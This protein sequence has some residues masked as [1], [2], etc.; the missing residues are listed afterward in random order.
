LAGRLAEHLIDGRPCPT[1]GATDHPD[2]ATLTDDTPGDDELEAAEVDSIARS[3]ERQRLEVSVGEARGKLESLAVID[4]V[5]D[6]DA[7]LAEARCELEAIDVAVGDQAVHRA[8]VER[9][10]KLEATLAEDVDRRRSE[11]DGLAGALAERRSRWTADRNAFVEEHGA[12]DSTADRADRLGS[13]VAAIEELAGN[14]E[15]ITVAGAARDGHRTALSCSMVEFGVDDPAGLERWARTPDQIRATRRQLDDR[16]EHRRLVT[17]RINTYVAADGPELEPDVGPAVEAEQRAAASH[18]DL[19]GRAAAMAAR[20][21]SLDAAI[22]ELG[23]GSEAIAR[24]LVAK[25]EADTLAGL[26]AGLGSGPDA[27]RLSLKNWVLAYY[28]RQVLAHAN[29]RLHTMTNGRYALDLSGEH[30]D[31]RRPWG[32]DISVRDAETGQ[33][34]PATTLSGGETFM[35]ALSLALGLADVVSAGSNYSIGALFVDEGFGSLD[36]DSLDTVIE[37]LR[38]LQDGGRM[39]GVISHVQELKDALPNGIE[40]VSTN[41]GSDATI[42]YPDA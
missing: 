23:E 13:L 26:C 17:A 1:C 40:I 16:A 9:L 41:H 29:S 35:A 7:R 20:L 14:L 8:E 5:A 27:S 11:V 34:R 10:A 42:H 22:A 39:V 19:V 38:S 12:F 32:L 36:G 30:A 4:D 3:E 31:G 25:E 28:L 2:P 6:L 15:A 18:D 21:G 24:A 37:V 33:S